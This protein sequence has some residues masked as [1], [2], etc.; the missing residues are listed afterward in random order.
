MLDLDHSVGSAGSAETD[1]DLRRVAAKSFAE[2]APAAKRRK[3]VEIGTI[4][5]I[6]SN[7]CFN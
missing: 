7:E 3:V 5:R 6:L 1:V 4:T 2:K